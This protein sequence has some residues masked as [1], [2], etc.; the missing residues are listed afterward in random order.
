[1]S[2]GHW[3]SWFFEVGYFN[4]TALNFSKGGFQS[5]RGNQNGGEFYVENVV[6]ELDFATEFF[7]DTETDV[8]TQAVYRCLS[9]MGIF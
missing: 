1:M 9:F 5:A 8:R 2:E 6:E 7:H 3:A 4:D